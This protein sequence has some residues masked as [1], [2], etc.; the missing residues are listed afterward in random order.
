MKMLLKILIVF[1]LIFDL[2][3]KIAPFFSLGKLTL[4]ILS[5]YYLLIQK[6]KTPVYKNEGK[7]FIVYFFISVYVCVI[8]IFNGAPETTS[9]ARIFY[10]LLYSVWVSIVFFTIFKNKKEFLSVLSSVIFIQSCFVIVSWLSLDFR[11]IVDNLLV[12][13][14]NISL[15]SHKR[16]PGLMNSAGAKASV[17]LGIGASTSLF[18]LIHTRT[19]SKVVLYTIMFITSSIATFIVGRTGLILLLALIIALLLYNYFGLI[20]FNNGNYIVYTV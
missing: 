4:I 12:E 17:I 19:Q 3:F 11:I 18:Q 7:V 15:L 14:G 5:I 2:S 1:S 13:T 10:Y 8:Y 16:P 6:D 9:L 20:L